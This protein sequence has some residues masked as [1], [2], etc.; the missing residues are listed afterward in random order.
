MNSALLKPMTC[1]VSKCF[2]CSTTAHQ[3]LSSPVSL[4]CSDILVD[5]VVACLTDV[6]F[7]TLRVQKDPVK[8]TS[9]SRCLLSLADL[10]RNAILRSGI[11]MACMSLFFRYL[12]MLYTSGS[13]K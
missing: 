12:D 3:W 8:S 9:L 4:V 5:D 1:S 11:R 13:M 6:C 2:E 10:K 7:T